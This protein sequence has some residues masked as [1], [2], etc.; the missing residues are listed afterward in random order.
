MN[1]SELTTVHTVNIVFI[2][3]L[4]RVSRQ[5]VRQRERSFEF[6]KRVI[7]KLQNMQKNR[8]RGILKP[9]LMVKTMK[10]S[11]SVK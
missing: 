5:K 1:Q 2:L 10:G 11:Y 6:F 4:D 7:Y 8:R 9:H 3:K